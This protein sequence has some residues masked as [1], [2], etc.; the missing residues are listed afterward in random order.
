MIV[1]G[2][3]AVGDLKDIV[4]GT[5]CLK[6]IAVIVCGLTVVAAFLFIDWRALLQRKQ[7]NLNFKIWKWRTK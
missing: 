7:L 4:H 5:F 3:Y 2:M 1:T 6:G